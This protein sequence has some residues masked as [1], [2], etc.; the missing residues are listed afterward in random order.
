L[1]IGKEISNQ[2]RANNIPSDMISRANSAV[3]SSINGQTEEIIYRSGGTGSVTPLTHPYL[4]PNSWIRV[5]PERGTKCMISRRAEDGEPYISAYFSEATASNYTKATDESRFY[6]KSLREGEIDLAT[7]GIA[8]VFLSRRGTVEIRGGLTSLKLHS[9][10]GEI[11]ARSPTHTRQVLGNKRQ[12]VGDEERFGVVQRPGALNVKFPGQSTIRNIVETIPTFFAKEYLRHLSS[13]G[14]IAG[15]TLVDHREGDVYQDSGIPLLSATTGRKLRSITKYGTEVPGIITTTEVDVDGNIS[16]SLPAS[17]IQGLQV[18]V[19]GPG[20]VKFT[21]GKDFVAN[22]L[23]SIIL[24]STT[25]DLKASATT[26]ATGPLLHAKNALI[27]LGS[28]ASSPAIKGDALMTW[29]G[30]LVTWLGTHSH[31]SSGAPPLPAPP[32]PVPP[33]TM[34]SSVVLI[35]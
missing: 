12:K 15:V 26:T 29:L 2:Q 7:P 10:G 20:N 6:Y 28:N 18:S 13:D 25:I 16:V 19:N 27:Q 34:L 3:I 31:P 33:A 8:N 4:G 23:K 32:I 17:A 9:D 35:K 5:M 14:P 21:V 11:Q 24:T 30:L 1:P 22:V